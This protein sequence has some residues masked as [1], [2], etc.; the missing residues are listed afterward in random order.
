MARELLY[1]G[2][3]VN[4]REAYRIGLVNKVVPTSDQKEG[5]KGFIEKRKPIFKNR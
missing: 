3:F 5:M 1:T 2:D 4:A